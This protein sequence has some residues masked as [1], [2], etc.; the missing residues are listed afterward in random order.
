[1]NW[2]II[3]AVAWVACAI[4]NY[5]MLFAYFQRKFTLIAEEYYVNDM[6]FSIVVS[7]VF[8]PFG[9]V[10]TLISRFYRHGFKWY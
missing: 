5:G 1:M 9:L 2:W 7:L 6:V 3:G 8:G 4:P 10:A